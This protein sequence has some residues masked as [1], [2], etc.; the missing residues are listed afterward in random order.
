MYK[1]AITVLFLF[2][3]ATLFSQQEQKYQ[4]KENAPEWVKLMYAINP[5]VGETVA[6]YNKYYQTHKLK[7]NKHTQYYKRWLREFSRSTLP[8]T[9]DN[10]TRERALQNNNGFI[11]KSLNLKN[12]KA[13]TS[14]WQCIG[15]W[16]FDKEAASRSYAPG[17]AHVYTVE[18]AENDSLIFYAGTATAGLWKSIDGGQNWTLATQNLLV[19]RIFAIEIDHSNSDI[20]Y[21]ESNGSVYKTLDGGVVWNIIGGAS[22]T[23]LSHNVK[24]IVMDP[25]NSNILYLTSDNGFYKTFDGGNNWLPVLTGNFQEIEI[26]PSN[27]DII[28]TIKQTG[29]KTEFLKSI[30]GGIIFIPK[31]NGWP[32]PSVGDEQ[33]RTEIAITPSAPNMIY[34]LA[35]GDANGGSGLYGIYVSSDEGESWTFRCCGPQPAG[36]PSVTNPNFFGWSK[37]GTDDGGQYYYDVA[38]AVDPADSNKIHVGGVNRWVS[39]DGGYN[40]TCPAKWSEPNEL[41]YVHA[42][43]HDIRYFGN[44]LWIAC[45]GGVFKST[46]GG[47]IINK[48]MLGIAGTDF[49]GFGASHQSSVMLGGAYHNGTLLKDNNT[50]INDWICTGGG[51]GVRGFV[52]YGNDRIAYDDYEGRIL[53][54]DR[55]V[56]IGSFNF[57]SL[58]NSSYIIG[59]SSRFAFDPRNY[60][61]IYFGRYNTLQKTP[62][63]GQTYE[64]IHDFGAEV[65]AVEIAWSNPDV[66]YVVTYESWWGAK[67]IWKS[68]DAGANWIEI[69]PPSSLL[70][71]NLW[72]PFDIA[73]SSNNPNILWA[74]RTSQYNGSPVLDGN[75][76]FKTIDGGLNWNN[77]T[78]STLDGEYITNII[79][80]RGTDGGVYIGTR[81]AVYYRNNTLPD[82]ELFNNNLPLSTPSTKLVPYYNERKLRNA[83]SRSVYEVEFYENSTPQA[84]LSSDK[85]IV[86]C[87]DSVVQFVDYSVLSNDNPTWQ[88]SF[89]G[90]IPNSS[91]Q[92]SPTVIYNTPGTYDV[93]LVVS[94]NYGTDSIS[95]SN[96]ITYTNNVASLNIVE[97]FANGLSPDWQLYNANQTFDWSFIDV[98]NGPDCVPTKCANLDHYSINQVGDEAELITPVIDLTGIINPNIIYDYAYARYGAGYEDGFR[99]DISND[100]G[101]NW[102]TLYQASGLA[103]ATVGDQ[104]NWWE[105]TNCTDWST[106]NLVSLLS[107]IGDQVMIRFVAIN[108]WGNNFY[109][110]NI[111]IVDG[112]VTIDEIE[113]EITLN[114]FPNP[115]KGELNIKHNSDNGYLE[116]FSLEGKRVFDSYLN[117]SLVAIKPLLSPG[118]YIVKLTESS[119]TLNKKI[120]ITN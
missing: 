47:A 28:Y 100:C 84:Q 87:Y 72:V 114:I 37:D 40:F 120:V 25:V 24:D 51:D 68:L 17:A 86:A 83:T 57:D 103:L 71:G 19:N 105:P 81:R 13:P 31:L 46:D 52:N 70:N 66:L 41:S 4:H 53:S 38:L 30:D 61:T 23:S 95:H 91:T 22:F 21:F 73:V 12:S 113:K 32:N 107:Y 44:D 92:Q 35:T 106:N 112:T 102:N 49:W 118:I 14:P 50:Y 104:A 56:A 58:P 59:A 8:L 110:D 69:T 74:A 115:S 20:V 34:A 7:K 108:G 10:L 79:H 82:W 11:Q 54:G 1:S 77:I 67:K 26:H 78:T 33:K 101:L 27:P 16:D 39:T 43:I 109:L 117:K 98:V 6:A 89:P 64:V 29:D 45:D 65:M 111:N 99:I 18:R 88:W 42:D 96:F 90:G 62:D 15:P 48:T 116:I 2:F 97:D 60:N 94:D 36:P 85:N 76:V 119:K 55:N 3:C 5:D 75:Q 9:N 93:S 63:N 80:Q